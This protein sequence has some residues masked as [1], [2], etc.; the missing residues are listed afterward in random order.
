MNNYEVINFASKVKEI[1]VAFFF[2]SYASGI[3]S[4]T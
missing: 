4:K 1:P 2:F 3:L